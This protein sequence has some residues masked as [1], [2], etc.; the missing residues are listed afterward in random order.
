MC[1]PRRAFTRRYGRQRLPETRSDSTYTQCVH[2]SLLVQASVSRAVCHAMT[3][4]YA[5]ELYVSAYPSWYPSSCY[6]PLGA[7][8]FGIVRQV[9]TRGCAGIYYPCP[10]MVLHA[11]R[12]M[13]VETASRMT[14]V[15]AYRRILREHSPLHLLKKSR[16]RGTFFVCCRFIESRMSR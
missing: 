15:L 10:D 5:L 11:A 9:A 3:E 4:Q 16:L 6:R 14:G 7:Y 2:T 8:Q 1:V 12:A 13:V